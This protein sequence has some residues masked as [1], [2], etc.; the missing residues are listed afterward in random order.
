MWRLYKTGLLDAEYADLMPLCFG[1]SNNGAIHFAKPPRQADDLRGLKVNASSRESGNIIAALGGT[2]TSIPTPN[3]YEALQRGTIDAS[4]IGWGGFA[5][6]KLH[7][8]TTYHLEGPLG[9]VSFMVAMSRSKHASLPAAGRKAIDDNSG[10]ALSR[11]FTTLVMA[12]H[13]KGRASVGSQP[14]VKLNLARVDWDRKVHAPIVAEWVKEVPGRDRV[15][16]TFN[17][18]YAEAEA[19]ARAKR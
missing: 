16:D 11:E 3:V 2:P 18:L 8:V 6:F 12:G 5:I 1:V 10:E 14:I 13:E 17:R 19:E 4:L 9:D 7:E 15:L